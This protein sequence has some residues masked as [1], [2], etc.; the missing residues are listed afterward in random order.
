MYLLI[1]IFLILPLYMMSVH[2]TMIDDT[3]KNDLLKIVFTI[4]SIS[5][6]NSLIPIL[7]LINEEIMRL[8]IKHYTLRSINFNPFVILPIYLLIMII[9]IFYQIIY[10]NIKIDEFQIQTFL[11]IWQWIICQAPISLI[12]IIILSKSINNYYEDRNLKMS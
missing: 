12:Y 10:K 7:L 3:R 2:N 11:M 5:C 1:E 6:I 9:E 8:F 4:F